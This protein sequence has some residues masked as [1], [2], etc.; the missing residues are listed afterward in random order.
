MKDERGVWR[1]QRYKPDLKR[2]RASFQRGATTDGDVCRVGFLSGVAATGTSLHHVSPHTGP[3]VM[4][5]LQLGWSSKS[6]LQCYGRVHRTEQLS[7]PTIVLLTSTQLAT[8]RFTAVVESRM[9]QLGAITSSARNVKNG[10][11]NSQ[12]QADFLTTVGNEAAQELARSRHIDLGTNED[13][14][15]ARKFLNRLLAMPVPRAN[16]LFTEFEQ[17]V[18][19]INKYN[20]RMGKGDADATP[21]I[22]VDGSKTC[23]VNTLPT[24]EGGNVHELRIDRGISWEDTLELRKEAIDGGMDAKHFYFCLNRNSIPAAGFLVAAA[25]ILPNQTMRLFRAYGAK[26]VLSMR[27]FEDRFDLIPEDQAK[28][29]W[30]QLYERSKTMCLHTHCKHASTCTVGRRLILRRMVT[31]PVF[32]LLNNLSRPPELRRLEF[33][34][35]SKDLA[36]EVTLDEAKSVVARVAAGHHV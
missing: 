10:L 8:A 27:E 33:A 34:D 24:T 26:T 9:R 35:G 21:L 22:K 28:P 13:R 29:L 5:S 15:T 19:E 2:E 17:L 32:T 6:V 30:E 25:H 11:S 31:L 20:A 23:L 4:I 14:D 1:P 3:R 18:D 36:V 16:K 7:D 12:D